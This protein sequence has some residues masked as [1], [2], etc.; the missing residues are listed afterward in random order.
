MQACEFEM[1]QAQASNSC[2]DIRANEDSN[3]AAYTAANT[4]TDDATYAAANT[5]A[6][7]ISNLLLL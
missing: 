3:N 4:P 1:L 5:C 7:S 6:D 2:P